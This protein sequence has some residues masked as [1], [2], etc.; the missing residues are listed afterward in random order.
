[1]LAKCVSIAPPWGKFWF[2]LFISSVKQLKVR[3]S[4]ERA[5]EKP[6]TPPLPKEPEV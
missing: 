4:G 2:I 3:A 1:M 5:Q 6:S